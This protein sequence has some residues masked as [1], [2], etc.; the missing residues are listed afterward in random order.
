[1]GTV[2]LSATKSSYVD[3]D[4][5]DTGYVPSSSSNYICSKWGKLIFGFSAFPSNL[6]RYK[7]VQARI[8]F[9]CRRGYG[10]M[11]FRACDSNWSPGGPTYR[12]QPS[13]G[14]CICDLAG[15]PRTQTS[16]D[17][18]A[19]RW[20]VPLATGVDVKDFLEKGG[21]ITDTTNGVY[22][23]SYEYGNWRLK[24]VLS[25][26]DAPYVEVTYDE[27]V[28]VKPKPKLS[29]SLGTNPTKAMTLNWTLP[30]DGSDYCLNESW[31]QTSAKLYYKPSGGS[32]SYISV[33]GSTMSATIP[34]NT[35]KTG[36]TYEYYVQVVD[37]AGNTTSSNSNSVTMITSQV[38]AQNSPTSGYV[39]LRV[40]NNFNWYFRSGTIT[41]PTGQV[42][43]HWRETGESSWNDVTAASGSN[44]L[45][46]PA[47]TFPIATTV[48]W[49]LSGTDSTGMSSSTP[50]YTF[51]TSANLAYA[52][53]VTPLNSVEDGS[54]PIT[55]V[56]NVTTADGFAP[57][58]VDL[59]WKLPETSSEEWTVALNH[60]DWTNNY[61]FAAGIFPA[62][63]CQW[64]VRAYNIDDVVGPW[65]YID[66][67][68]G[69]YPSFINVVA[70]DEPV[71]TTDSA[72]FP[73]VYWQVE[74]QQSYEIMI[75]S[76]KYGP[77]FGTEKTFTSPD[78]L[79]DGDHTVVVRVMGVY[80]LW[81]SW[82]HTL[83]TVE[84]ESVVSFRLRCNVNIDALLTW[85]GQLYQ[86]YL[87]Y[88]D[89]VQ[90]GHTSGL[91]F[92][93]RVALGTHDYFVVCRKTNGHYIKS[94]VITKTEEV[95]C[96]H[97]AL[98][99]GGE[100]LRIIHT[101]KSIGDPS[102]NDKMATA[103]NQLAGHTYPIV[104]MSEFEERTVEYSAVFL[105]NEV[106]ER[107]VFESMLRKPVILKTTGG[108]VVIGVLD[109]WKMSTMKTAYTSYTFSVRRID[110]RDYIDV[111]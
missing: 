31:T 85:E 72:P 99:E 93:D 54:K 19:D 60:A 69:N 73:T 27:S 90:I 66:G 29:N 24:S 7:L 67:V 92:I 45:T 70:P 95:D 37:N 61:T 42:T 84:N 87:I 26:G 71:V 23:D 96:L 100:W 57:S 14:Y 102:Y 52:T 107:R 15:I 17:S 86:D 18:W 41:I 68:S 39:N 5:P 11:G 20:S 13:Q 21:L 40:A 9:Y 81:S 30:K 16:A 28:V 77:Y 10:Y 110:W 56:W 55:M 78:Y 109:S 36:T 46:I 44:G 59:W 111:S 64:M 104:E 53:V 82:G 91:E 108:E 4:T 38:V 8:I 12:N 35:L 49:Y 50:T 25:G 98:L 76:K 33:S 63:E 34:A 88:R 105:Y 1:M 3:L 97:I 62:G 2:N 43:F 106:A 51:S 48:Q 103:Y 32:W 65:S 101:L 74:G 79:E 6:N 89:G 58:H 22:T 94:H 47:N 83:F 75:D 80:G